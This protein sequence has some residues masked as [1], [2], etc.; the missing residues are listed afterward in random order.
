MHHVVDPQAACWRLAS[1]IKAA[2]DPNHVLAP[3]RYN[4]LP[5]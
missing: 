1:A 4:I 2:I 5:G 3:G